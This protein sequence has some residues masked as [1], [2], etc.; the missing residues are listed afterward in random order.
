MYG[1]S[2][3][4]YKND[5]KIDG[6]SSEYN[7]LHK[8]DV[9]CEATAWFV[10]VLTNVLWNENEKMANSKKEQSNDPTL[11]EIIIEAVKRAEQGNSAVL[12]HLVNKIMK[13][14]L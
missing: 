13:K 6:A 1:I 12:D 3:S 4:I 14:E 9:R 2:F 5:K 10:E 11:K 7:L 8:E